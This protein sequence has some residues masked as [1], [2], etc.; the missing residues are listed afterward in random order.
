MQ[1]T[2]R[3]AATDTEIADTPIR[4]WDT[5]ALVL[6]AAN[7]DP[8]QFTEPD[9][10]DLTRTPSRHLGFG[11]GPH[12]CLGAA[13]TRTETTIA[14]QALLERYPNLAVT[15]PDT[16]RYRPD[17]RLRGLERLDLTA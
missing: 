9:R 8:A 3:T 17:H 10:L 7:R 5:L 12:F 4:Q 1:L 16:I 6:G 2:N 11:L 13:L 15:H 14:L